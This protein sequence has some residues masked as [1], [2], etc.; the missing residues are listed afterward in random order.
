MLFQIANIIKW[1]Y[2]LYSFFICVNFAKLNNVYLLALTLLFQF[3]TEIE[4][5]AYLWI[6]LIS[7]FVNGPIE[8]MLVSNSIITQTMEFQFILQFYGHKEYS[9]AQTERHW[10]YLN[11]TYQPEKEHTLKSNIGKEHRQ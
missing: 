11:F 9:F 4:L 10:K 8:K 1:L 2:W 7:K 3:N 6:I 5:T